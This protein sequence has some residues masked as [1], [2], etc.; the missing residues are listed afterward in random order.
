[1]KA[2]TFQ[3]K[4]RVCYESVDDPGI[5]AP[6]DLVVKV[7]LAGICGSDL[8]PYHEREPLD[9]GTVLGHEFVGEV[10]ALGPDVKR[11]RRGDRVFSPF[12][13]NCGSCSYCR[14]SLTSR[15]REGQL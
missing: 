5:E 8:H 4:E 2:L 12:T 10:V 15:C 14:N 9:S 11:F 13:T 6:S 1:M 7:E 3:S